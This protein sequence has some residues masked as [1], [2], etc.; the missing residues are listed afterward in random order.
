MSY[1]VFARYYDEL[2]Q[3]VEYAEIADKIT[4]WLSEHRPD[5]KLL[6]DMACGTGTLASLLSQKGY[7]VIG[8]DSSADMLMTAR[9][10][11][12]PEV[13]LLCQSMDEIDLYG[14]VDAV[15]CTLDSINHVTDKK[16]VGTIFQK[17]SLFLE[18]NGIFVFDVNTPYKHEHILADSAYIIETD[19]VF[20][21]WQNTYEDGLVNISLDFFEEEDGVY[22]R[23][24][25]C[26][27]ERA[28][29]DE[30]IRKMLSEAELEVIAVKDDYSDKEP[31]EETQRL[32]YITKRKTRK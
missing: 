18:N 9:G 29:T 21:A 10:K 24:S 14:T 6:V 16:T 30:E 1:D 20:C 8:I 15:V 7:D 27:S 25:E 22:Y 19:N 11:C 17:V 23:S 13:L 31:D 3:N 26:F 2:M 28:Y 4:Q 12:P 5:S 32:V